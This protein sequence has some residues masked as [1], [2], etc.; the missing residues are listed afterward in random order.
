MEKLEDIIFYTLE[1]AI[2]S[3]RQYAQHNITAAGIDI[4][5]DQW[6]LLKA[7][8]ENPGTPQNELAKTVFKDMASITRMIELMVTKGFLIRNI[9]SNDRRRS[10]LDLTETG[11]LILEVIQPVI[12]TNR[13]TAL[14]TLS[15]DELVLLDDLLSRITRNTSFKAERS[16][17]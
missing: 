15:K 1:R 9:N 10:L 16:G 8:Q 7:I 13:N 12:E 14:D 11:L 2:K 5:I 17:N 4:T 6:L 3:Y